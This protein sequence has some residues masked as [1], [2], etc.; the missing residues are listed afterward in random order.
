MH[1]DPGNL[2]ITGYIVF[3]GVAGKKLP[4]VEMQTSAA[5]TPIY[6][7]PNAS[8]KANFLPGLCPT[9]AGSRREDPGTMSKPSKP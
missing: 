8:M 3:P 9:T 1:C 2:T 5:S 6:P 7:K 4:V